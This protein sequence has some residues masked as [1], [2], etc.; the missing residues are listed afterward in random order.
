MEARP[1][2]FP[3][4][5]VLPVDPVDLEGQGLGIAQL[6]RK[7]VPEAAFV[8]SFRG[9]RRSEQR[10]L[11]LCEVGA[12][13]DGAVRRNAGRS[14]RSFCS[15]GEERATPFFARIAKAEMLKEAILQNFGARRAPAMVLDS[16]ARLIEAKDCYQLIHG[17]VAQAADLLEERCA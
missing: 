5:R 10:E 14:P 9:P 17:D 8:L 12:H 1:A 2:G 15:N 7:P 16:L 3:A 11:D 6:L 4:V 13:R